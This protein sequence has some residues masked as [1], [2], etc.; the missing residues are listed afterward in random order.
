MK[1][2]TSLLFYATFFLF[3]VSGRTE[4]ASS[5]LVWPIYQ[6]IEADQ[7]GSALWLENRGTEEVI[8]QV[9]V[10]AW[11]QEDA[12]EV[13]AD[14]QDVIASPPF[15]TIT[16]GERQLIRLMRIK[17]VVPGQERPFRIVI[18]E[19]PSE[20]GSTPVANGTADMSTGLRLQMRYLLPLFVSGEGIWTKERYDLK[21]DKAS[22]SRPVLSWKK[23][24]ENGQDMLVIQNKGIVHARLSNVFWSDE[25]QDK[26]NRQVMTEG[27][28][29]YVL[30]GSV[31]RWALPPGST[32]PDGKVLH[33]QLEDNSTP[34][35]IPSGQ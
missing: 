12:D 27:F 3:T 19:I 13:Y 4:A 28:L 32:I 26:T 16:P 11:K 21:R 29:G 30:P 22:A 31:M 18:D 1:T 20:T 5:I 34:I 17:P 35:L 10:L 7:N 33:A 6:T 25:N 15:M 2:I 8:L 24:K 23:A 9:R 14:Q